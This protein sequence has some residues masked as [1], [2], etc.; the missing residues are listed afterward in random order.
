MSEHS[1]AY[2]VRS[3]YS[4]CDTKCD[5]RAALRSDTDA[6]EGQAGGPLWEPDGDGNYAIWGVLA[7]G[8][9]TAERTVTSWASGDAMVQ[10][11]QEAL[12]RWEQSV[13]C[14]T[15]NRWQ[16]YSSRFLT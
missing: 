11:V 5:A 15:L 12:E 9:T 4:Q 10:T 3:S 1:Y 16:G 13:M 2:S 8:E 6:I 7:G 14:D